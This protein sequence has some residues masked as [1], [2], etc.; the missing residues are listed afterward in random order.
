MDA[1]SMLVGVAVAIG[2]AGPAQALMST[3]SIHMALWSTVIDNQTIELLQALGM[4]FGLASVFV[5]GLAQQI[6]NVCWSK[7]K[8]TE[9]I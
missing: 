2:I 4:L 3:H 5:I 7:Q 1:G 8:K 9:P 6:M